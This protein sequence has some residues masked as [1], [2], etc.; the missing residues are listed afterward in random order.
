MKIKIS[1]SMPRKILLVLM[2]LIL[3]GLI[4]AVSVLILVDDK[5]DLTEDDP[6]TDL[7]EIQ[8]EQASS[9]SEPSIA[10]YNTPDNCWVIYQS[11][12]YDVSKILSDLADINEDSCGTNLEKLSA[13]SVVK[14]APYIVTSVS[15]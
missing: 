2:G 13:D 5:N 3:A 15:N 1:K 6:I 8:F 4:I 9:F 10:Q 14:I 11:S 12:V 7:T